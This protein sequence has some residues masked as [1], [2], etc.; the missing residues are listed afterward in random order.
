V[1][2]ILVIQ[3]QR[4]GDLILSFPL[5]L[6][7]ER[8]FPGTPIWV[9]AEPMFSGPLA[10]LSP[11][12]R[13]FGFHQAAELKDHS[14]SL[15]INL[16]HRPESME[17]AGS[18]DC[19]ELLGGYSRDGV[20]RINGVW[21]EYR[22][23]LTHNNRHNRFHWAELNS[24]DVIPRKIMASTQWPEARRMPEQTN[25]VGL[26]LGASEADKRPAAMF[27]AQLIACLE[28]LGMAPML[29]GGPSEVVLGKEVQ[30]LARRPVAS[31]CGT[32]RLE[33]LA[34]L[35]QS[36]AL[37]ITP[38]TGP[39]HLSAWTGLRTINLSMGPVHAWETGPYQP[40]HLVMRAAYSCVGCWKCR[41][42]APRCHG[43]FAPERV[44]R[45]AEEFR[46]GRH[47]R[48]RGMRL[49][50]LDLSLSGRGQGHY[51]LEPLVPRQTCTALIGQYWQTFWLHAFAQASEL[52]C[53][54]ASR[55]IF[56]VN[57]SLIKLM[58]RHSLA[59]LFNISRLAQRPEE[60]RSATLL[61]VSPALQPLASYLET[62]LT[63]HDLS[64]VALK[65]A[66]GL[67]ELHLL[68][69]RSA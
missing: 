62:H 39:M 23:S 11:A 42:D 48:L 56:A 30:R 66:V 53:V 27:W 19:E 36:L 64:S 67:V 61:R 5:F 34:M 15:V 40:G 35:G 37:V 69:L 47:D 13:Y 60:F 10:P 14:F 29:L 26:F 43:P 25:R 63:N 58:I 9:M 52:A 59:L 44:A 1:K 68:I 17:L 20:T 3:M 45:V 21:Q 55:A 32:L 24:L 46:Y 12:V 33:Q 22:T 41:Y 18:L 38:D 4:M 31:A 8:S 51:V 65:R 28:K 7:L 2:P 6:W 16:S 57:P 50:G 49:P 54:E